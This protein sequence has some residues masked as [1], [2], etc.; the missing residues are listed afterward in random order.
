MYEMKLVFKLDL[1]PTPIND[2]LRA[3]G[4]STLFVEDAAE[5]SISQ[6]VSF[7]P[8]EETLHQYETIIQENYSNE[9]FECV[10]CQIAGYEYLK[11]IKED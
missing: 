8:T 2:L 9:K 7:I 6:T 4:Q 3:C 1:A 11:E 5:V 10:G